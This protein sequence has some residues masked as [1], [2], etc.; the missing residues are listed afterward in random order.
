MT[1]LQLKDILQTSG[2]LAEVEARMFDNMSLKSYYQNAKVDTRFQINQLTQRTQTYKILPKRMWEDFLDYYDSFEQNVSTTPLDPTTPIGKAGTTD[3]GYEVILE[4]QDF[5][6]AP[7][8]YTPRQLALRQ[9]KNGSTSPQDIAPFTGSFDEIPEDLL[10]DNLIKPMALQMDLFVMRTISKEYQMA[11]AV[12]SRNGTMMTKMGISKKLNSNADRESYFTSSKINAIR[13]DIANKVAGPNAQR[14]VTIELFLSPQS[15]ESLYAEMLVKKGYST[16]TNFNAFTAE[17]SASKEAINKTLKTITHTPY[18]KVGEVEAAFG[19]KITVIAEG[20]H[21]KVSQ[22]YYNDTAVG[23][24]TDDVNDYY[25]NM[26]SS[27]V[28]T[29]SNNR[30]V[31]EYA[32]VSG[33]NLNNLI[34]FFPTN[35]IGFMNDPTVALSGGKEATMMGG[36]VCMKTGVNG[37]ANSNT[38]GYTP[39]ALMFTQF[40]YVRADNRN[41][42]EIHSQQYDRTYA[43]VNSNNNRIVATETKL[44]I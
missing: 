5:A 37:M 27:D 40:Y 16:V 38:Y 31:K 33:T 28:Y 34:T 17:M 36:M 26:S 29:P 18:D 21:K 32:V 19:V 44:I 24:N 8:S 20:I 41:I 42:Y 35:F 22:F 39:R 2:F 13:D 25:D 30:I 1:E 11:Q 12:E 7:L 14:N 10:E 15:L 6:P 43:G 9:M 23:S 4:R 3:L